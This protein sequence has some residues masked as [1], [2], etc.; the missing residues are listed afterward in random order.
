MLH[1]LGCQDALS[2]A[3]VLEARTRLTFE[4]GNFAVCQEQINHAL[5]SAA[6]VTMEPVQICTSLQ[7]YANFSIDI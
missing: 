4:F 2:V 3:V 6:E 1:S 5:T 7:A